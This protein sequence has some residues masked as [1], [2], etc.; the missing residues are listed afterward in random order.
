MLTQPQITIHRM[1]CVVDAYIPLMFQISIPFIHLF[2]VVCIF[3][4]YF[5]KIFSNVIAVTFGKYFLK[6]SV[7]Y[8]QNF[9]YTHMHSESRFIE[10][11]AESDL[12]N[13]LIGLAPFTYKIFI[14]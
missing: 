12:K 8:Y 6:D 10:T 14:E 1:Q 7:L 5:R 2:R 13:E 3:H 9:V 4:L 11:S